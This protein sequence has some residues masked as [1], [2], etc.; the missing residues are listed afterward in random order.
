M[1]DTANAGCITVDRQET[2]GLFETFYICKNTLQKPAYTIMHHYTDDE[3]ILFFN[4][5]PTGANIICT[6]YEVSGLK[7]AECRKAGT[8][9]IKSTFKFKKNTVE[10]L[11]LSQLDDKQ[12]ESIYLK[13]VFSY[14]DIVNQIEE[15]Q[16]FVHVGDDYHVTLGYDE[17]NF[18]ALSTCLINFETF[19]KKNKKFLMELLWR[20]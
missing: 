18:M 20:K 7:K 11:N 6:D 8:R 9:P 5:D 19:F 1:P 2:P 12:R 14:P 3:A 4:F 13:K 10:M 17:K 16:C 15:D